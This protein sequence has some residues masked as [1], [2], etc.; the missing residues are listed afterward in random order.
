MF[1][2]VF[3][4]P[5]KD[6]HPVRICTSS[7]GPERES[8]CSVWAANQCPWATSL[9]CT[10]LKVAFRNAGRRPF[11]KSTIRQPV[12]GAPIERPDR[13]RGIDNRDRRAVPDQSPDGLLSQ[14]LGTLVRAATGVERQ[15]VGLR[16]EPICGT[17]HRHGTG[18]VDDPSDPR[19]PCRLQEPLREVQEYCSHTVWIHVRFSVVWSNHQGIRSVSE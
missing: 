11:R 14:D 9:T 16:A 8:P 7:T 18:R 10:K 12:G 19:L 3:R 4:G 2:L 1:R 17:A 6:D 5:P 15:E 13:C